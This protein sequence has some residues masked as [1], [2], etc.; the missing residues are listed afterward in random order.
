[1]PLLKR[2]GALFAVNYIT[3]CQIHLDPVILRLSSNSR[4]IPSD[5]NYAYEERTLPVKD[6]G[7]VSIWHIRAAAP[8]KGFV[9]VIPDNDANKGRYSVVLPIF[10]DK[11]WDVVLFDYPGFGKG[12]DTPTLNG[13]VDSARAVLDYAVDQD[14]VV[15]GIGVRLGTGV[16][17][18]VAVD[19][20]SAWPLPGQSLRRR[21]GVH[22]GRQTAMNRG[23]PQF[24]DAFSTTSP[25]AG[26][27]HVAALTCTHS[28]RACSS[29]PS[30]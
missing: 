6:D 7:A 3:G 22:S 16:L 29:D 27:R 1:M 28:A 5:L 17:A 19:C 15:V 30:A 24:P 12:P 11:S 9:V 8:S 13:L 14:D 25:R 20:P 4:S 2:I 26:I 10:V 21:H 23:L 18:R